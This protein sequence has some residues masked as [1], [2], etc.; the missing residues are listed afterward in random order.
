LLSGFVPASTFTRTLVPLIGLALT[1]DYALYLARRSRTGGDARYSR[2]TVALA[3]GV[4]ALGFTGLAVAPTGELRQAALAGIVTCAMAAL[5]AITLRPVAHASAPAVAIPAGADPR[6]IRWGSFVVRRPWLVLAASA[7]PLAL[8]ANAARSARL[9]TPL[10]EL[11]P[12]GMESA[13]AFR[14]LQRANRAGAATILRVVVEMPEGTTVMTDAGWAALASTT[15]A[16]RGAAGVADA[17]SITSIGNGDLFVAK[18]IFPRAVTGTFVSRDGRAAIIDVMPDLSRGAEPVLDLVRRVRAMDAAAATGVRGAQFSVAGL[19]AYALDYQ[20]A[21][22]SSL[23]WIVLGTSIATLVALL[24]AFRAPLIALK[25][26]ALNLLVAAAA[27]GATVLVFQD[28]F[29]ASLMGRHALGS[30]FPTVPA[31]AF[32]AAFGTS[33]DYEL[34][35]LGAVGEAKREGR[36]DSGAIV[37]GLSRTGGLITRAAAVMACLFLAFSTSGLLPLAMVGF[38]LAVAVALDATLVRLALAPSILQIAGRW[39]WWPGN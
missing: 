6:W 3:A 5:A 29:G 15:R 17:R 30:I 22:A 35:L 12:A 34:F 14:D 39:N 25:A 1:V 23:P 36:D 7:F 26:V 27:I 28:G 19:P 18:N 11:L 32:G 21:V 33:M 38:A 16:L 20:T 4:V 24:F 9:I 10:D 8:L 2:R 37:V 13:D 31:L